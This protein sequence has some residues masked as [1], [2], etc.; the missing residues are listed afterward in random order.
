MNRIYNFKSNKKNK[1]IVK[2]IIAP[3]LAFIII[4]FCPFSSFSLSVQAADTVVK[5]EKFQLDFTDSNDTGTVKINA[6]EKTDKKIK[7]QI[8]Q[9]DTKYD[10]DLNGE[11]KV[12]SYPM[13]WGNGEYT[14]R[15]MLQSSANKY[16]VGI[17]TKYTLNLKEPNAIFMNANQIVNFTK[18]SKIVK[19]AAELIK[20]CE[21]EL[22]RVEAI[23][24]F[25]IDSLK[26]DTQLA[27]N[28]PVGYVPDVDKVVDSGK[29]ICFDYAAV[30]AA[31]LRSQGI[32]AKLVMGH[33][34]SPSGEAV[35]HAWN[36]FYLKDKG[37]WF[38]INEMK[39]EGNGRFERVDP[40]LESSNRKDN[41]T[42]K[43][44][45]KF[46]GDGSNYSKS[47]EF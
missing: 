30:F 21:T 2:Y 26:Y 35:Y 41:K 38:M 13:Q 12:E 40:T 19:K 28:P 32:P 20:G 34:K 36:E 11:G 25:V 47:W 31:M 45:V 10:Y 3:L 39:L 16:S 14:V 1:R 37:G 6:L 15:V 9:G 8:L 43:A 29:G 33:V 4:V 24:V 18:D 7:V 5:N 46:I 17:S 27:S 42:N 22:A 44:M 23:Y